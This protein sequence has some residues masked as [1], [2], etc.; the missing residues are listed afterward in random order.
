[1]DNSISS[2]IL[3]SAQEAKQATEESIKNF[4]N[5]QL[6]DISQKITNAIADGDFSIDHEGNWKI[7]HI[8]N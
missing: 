2:D 6:S 4:N 1:M 8:K 3:W 5:Q 7:K